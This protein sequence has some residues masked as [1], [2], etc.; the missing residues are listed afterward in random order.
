MRLVLAFGF[1]LIGI[2]CGASSA[3]DAAVQEGDLHEDAGADAGASFV[4]PRDGATYPTITTGTKT[5][6]AKN[7]AFK[8]A[9]GSYCY[10]DDER[11][12]ASD[13][14]LYTFSVARTTAC[15]AGTHLPS[16]DDWK[17]LEVGLGMKASQL[18][19]EGYSTARGTDEGTK[20]KSPAGFGA[21][22]AGYRQGGMY[23][24]R[25]D[26]T[27]FWTSTMR[28][29]DVWRRRI[30]VAEANIFRFTNAPADFAIS[31]RCV[32]D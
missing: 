13:G 20:A 22:P 10:D 18:D 6:F 11:N 5:W 23:D 16:D 26:R 17:S 8:T 15:P 14:R 4:D 3:S 31:V 30:S 7:L 25:F 12:C 32:L 21:K 28:G 2:A 27:Y 19:L 29:S 24:A 9:T 1:A